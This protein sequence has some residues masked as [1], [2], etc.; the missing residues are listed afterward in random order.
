MLLA[1]LILFDPLSI[2][3]ITTHV[4]PVS[5]LPFICNTTHTKGTVQYSINII[6][7]C[8]LSWCVFIID[9]LRWYVH[10]RVNTVSTS[11][12]RDYCVKCSSLISQH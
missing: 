11:E 2:I 10:Y 8:G 5:P 6:C 9:S 12:T 4:S 1:H 7:L 3:L